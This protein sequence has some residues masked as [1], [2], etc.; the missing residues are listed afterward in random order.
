MRD[1]DFIDKLNFLGREADR[2][3]NG[4]CDMPIEERKAGFALIAFSLED[5]SPVEITTNLTGAGMV[6]LIDKLKD[7]L[8]EIFGRHNG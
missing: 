3:F 7:W 1:K 5:D 6:D 2:L 4:G 8:P